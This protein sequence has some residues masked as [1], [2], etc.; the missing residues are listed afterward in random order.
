MA[1]SNTQSTSQAIAPPLYHGGPQVF[2]YSYFAWNSLAY[3]NV[4][5]PGSQTTQPPGATLAAIPTVPAHAPVLVAPP[6]SSV[7][8]SASI[9]DTRTPASD[10]SERDFAQLVE[11]VV[12]IKAGMQAALSDLH[13]IK[14][15]QKALGDRVSSLEGALGVAQRNKAG[16]KKKAKGKEKELDKGGEPEQAAP[17]SEPSVSN[18]LDRLGAIEFAV[19]ELLD[20]TE[21][22]QPIKGM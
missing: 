16:R 12:G 15:T 21:K 10:G 4:A 3:H 2:P 5:A 1:D 9:R 22:R 19:E 13:A 17:L 6:H 20:R 8:P 11:H 14:G 18:V 7:S